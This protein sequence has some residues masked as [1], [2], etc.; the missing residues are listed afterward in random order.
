MKKNVYLLLS[1]MMIGT[2][3]LAQKN[4]NEIRI[5][6]PL[7]EPAPLEEIR[8]F[9]KYQE[10]HFKNP[11]SRFAEFT[12]NENTH[13]QYYK[14]KGTND[15]IGIG[16]LLNEQTISNWEGHIRTHSAMFSGG[17][18]YSVEYVDLEEGRGAMLVVKDP[19]NIADWFYYQNKNQGV[20]LSLRYISNNTFEQRL[21]NMRRILRELKVEVL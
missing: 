1:L 2:V 3:T 8:D 21:E 11:R 4:L 13:T 19:V 18:P 5:I 20:T 6:H 10:R 17:Q 7:L 15:I 14:L 16:G 9:Q 12:I